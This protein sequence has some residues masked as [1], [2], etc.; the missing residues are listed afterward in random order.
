MQCGH[1]GAAQG[2]TNILMPLVASMGNRIIP[3]NDLSLGFG[4]YKES[5]P[6]FKLLGGVS[7]ICSQMQT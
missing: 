1:E 5:E 3:G 6:L 7:V 4:L 2:Q